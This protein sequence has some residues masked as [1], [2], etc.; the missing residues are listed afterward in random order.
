MPLGGMGPPGPLGGNGGP[1]VPGGGGM[2]PI[3]PPWDGG[4][5]PRPV[6]QNSKHSLYNECR[7]NVNKV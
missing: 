1:C 3:G 7:V 6:L 4:G 5:G 2:L